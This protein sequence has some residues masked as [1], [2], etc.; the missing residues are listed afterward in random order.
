LDTAGQASSLPVARTPD[1]GWAL[2]RADRYVPPSFALSLSHGQHTTC[3][4]PAIRRR[5]SN[6]PVHS[7]P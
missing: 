4:S 6:A 2:Y 1:A 5:A 7:V 3:R